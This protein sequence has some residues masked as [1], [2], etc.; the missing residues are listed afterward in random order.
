MAQVPLP[1]RDESRLLVLD[2][3]TGELTHRQFRALPEYLQ[4]GDLLILNRSRVVPARLIGRLSGGGRAE[5]LYL[6]PD[7]ARPAEFRALVRPGRRLRAGA[8]VSLGENDRCRVAAV[9]PDG[10]RTMSFEGSTG[11]LDLLQRLGRLPLPPYIDRAEGPLDRARYQTVYASEPG[12][13]A[14]PTAGLHFTEE[15]L[16][17]L[18]SNGV[19][20]REVVLHVG[21]GTFARVDVE[22]IES[23][24]VPPEPIF[25]PDETAAAYATARQH[26]RRVI[27]VGTTTVRTLEARVKDDR[28]TPG[29][30]ETSL[31][32]RP[33]HR[34][35][36]VDALVTNFHL[37]KSSLLFLVAAF[38]GRETVLGA[39]AEAIRARYRFYSYG[40]AMLIL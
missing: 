29:S 8:V 22:D 26:G 28:L 35:R 30:G 6:F 33:G 1:V 25:V 9:H 10:S 18:R 36:A 38:A 34:F 14:A 3:A 24:Q 17:R 32:I 5:I 20:V 27:A 16:T 40:D 19:V 21:P 13:V 23:H 12:S 37:P 11:V 7:P 39:Y 4:A 15:L 31:V 2:R